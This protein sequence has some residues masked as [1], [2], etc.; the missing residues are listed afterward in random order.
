[1]NLI[2][3]RRRQIARAAFD[4]Y[5]LERIVN[6][7]LVTEDG[8]VDGRFLNRAAKELGCSPHS[9]SVAINM[10]CC[11][12]VSMKVTKILPPDE[13]EKVLLAVAKYR[14]LEITAPLKNFKREFGNLTAK[15]NEK[16]PSLH[17]K[18]DEL[19]Q[20]V[21]PIYVEVVDEVFGF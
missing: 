1:M 3:K 2:P 10:A 9:L 4:L 17:L 13:E 18:T 12:L 7:E 14:I 15:I 6:E 16:Y 8:K 20:Y 11:R 19:L 5:V 21:Y